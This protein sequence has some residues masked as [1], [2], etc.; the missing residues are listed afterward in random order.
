MELIELQSKISSSVRQ[1]NALAQGIVKSTDCHS[2]YDME[3]R[4]TKLLASL[5]TLYGIKDIMFP[6]TCD[7]GFTDAKCPGCACYLCQYNKD[8]KQHGQ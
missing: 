5:T 8:N 2:R 1:M 7:Y 4:H 3:A 6:G